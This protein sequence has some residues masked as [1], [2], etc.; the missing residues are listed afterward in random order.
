MFTCLAVLLVPIAA[1]ANGFYFPGVGARASAMGGA[2]MGLADDFSAIYWN[3]AG[4]TQL[5]GMEVTATLADAVTLASRDGIIT[6]DGAPG[7]EDGYRRASGSIGATSEGI[8][9][10][11]PGVFFCA[12]PGPAKGLVDKVGLGVYTLSDV[13]VKWDGNDV[14]SRPDLLSG[15]ANKFSQMYFTAD[16]PDYESRLKT[17]V[18]S[19]VVARE[20]L[21]GVS[22]GLA[23]NI[24]YSHFVMDDVLLIQQ[25]VFIDMPDPVEDEWWLFL[26][27]VRLSDD[28]TGWGVGATLGALVRLNNQV[29]VGLTVRSPMSINYDGVYS[30]RVASGDETYEEPYG[31]GFEIRY[32]FW[33]GSGLA[34]RDFLFDGL[35]MTA[36]LQWTKWSD[37]N[38][39]Y[40]K[41]DWTG[42]MVGQ[43]NSFLEVVDLEWE[44]TLEFAMGFDYRVGRSVNVNLGYRHSPSPAPNDTYNFV[45]PFAPSNTI[46]LGMTY[47]QD[48]WRLAA[49]LEYSAG[50]TRR[51]RDTYDMNGKHVVDELSPSLSLTY[52]F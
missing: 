26:T 3:P 47:R 43:D 8:N 9:R 27:P 14:L 10:L 29:S 50:D 37:L 28:A 15:G 39:I 19:P 6:L 12:D 20:V 52:A 25:S 40:R 21:P 36:D 4:I 35:T 7:G 13:G 31:V 2:F 11:V 51:L 42:D 41:I 38:R 34:Y 49:A 45:I 32:P 1:L 44:S 24:A 33:I 46:A 16:M 23:A 18:V 5:K 22:V 48:F 30:V 17:Y